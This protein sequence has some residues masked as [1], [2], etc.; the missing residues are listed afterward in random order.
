MADYLAD[1][2]AGQLDADPQ[3]SR[4][5]GIDERDRANL[6]TLGVLSRLPEFLELAL[7]CRN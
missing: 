6:E 1:L 5:T 3:G 2:L 7:K 4:K